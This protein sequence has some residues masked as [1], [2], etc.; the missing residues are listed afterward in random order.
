MKSQLPAKTTPKMKIQGYEQLFDCLNEAIIVHDE[1]GHIINANKE[2]V[3]VTGY[4]KKE[5][6]SMTVPDIHPEHVLEKS[7]DA[8]STI[9][10]MGHIRFTTDFM[11]KNGQIFTGEVSA[12]LTV[13]NGRKVIQG[14]LCDISHRKSFEQEE[15]ASLRP[16]VSTNKFITICCGCKKLK[17]RNH[18]SEN[19]EKIE[20]YLM[21]KHK[22]EISHGLCPECIEKY[23]PEE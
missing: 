22:M 15:Q 7:K 9:E 23:Y 3:K 20:S 14:I 8:F 21:D 19:W 16:S 18:T 6:T 13:L 10:E 4:S 17:K 1:Q 5:L 11:R 12:S 2:A